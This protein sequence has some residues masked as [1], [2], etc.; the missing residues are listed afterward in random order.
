MCANAVY[1]LFFFFL[2]VY[3][4]YLSCLHQDLCLAYILLGMQN[5]FVSIFYLFIFFLIFFLFLRFIFCFLFF[6][7]AVDCI[8]TEKKKRKEKKIYV[9]QKPPLSL[10]R[11]MKAAVCGGFFCACAEMFGGRRDRW[12]RLFVCLF[13]CVCLCMFGLLTRTCEGLVVSFS[14]C[15]LG[16]LVH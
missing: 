7:G 5:L 10:W 6:F 9:R 3:F 15:S 4:F 16:L 8:K 1:L 14:T 13:V 12:T 2:C 11:E